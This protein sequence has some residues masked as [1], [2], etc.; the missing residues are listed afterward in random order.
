M[1]SDIEE[2]W[3]SLIKINGASKHLNSIMSV[4]DVEEKALLIVSRM[5]FIFTMGKLYTVYCIIINIFL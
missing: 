5:L 3:S 2:F 1:S 4:E